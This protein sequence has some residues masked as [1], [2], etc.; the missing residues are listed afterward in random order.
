M[1][2]VFPET[3]WVS[4]AAVQGR[5]SQCPI[6]SAHAAVAT[7]VLPAGSPAAAAVEDPPAAV[8]DGSKRLQVQMPPWGSL[9]MCFD[10]HLAISVVKEIILSHAGFG[11]P[12]EHYLSC[13]GRE[14]HDDDTIESTAIAAEACVVMHRR[15]QGG[16]V[17][18]LFVKTLNGNSS[19]TVHASPYDDVSVLHTEIH[20]KVGIPVAA[21]R[22]IFEGRSLE[23]GRALCDYQVRNM[24]TVHLVLR[25]RG[26][27]P[28][29]L[30]TRS[31]SSAEAGCSSAGLPMSGGSLLPTSFGREDAALLKGVTCVVLSKNPRGTGD[32]PRQFLCHG[33]AQDGQ[34]YAYEATF[35]DAP[36]TCTKVDLKP[37]LRVFG[38]ITALRQRGQ[39]LVCGNPCIPVLHRGMRAC[40]QCFFVGHP[41][42]DGS[43]RVCS[44]DAS[45]SPPDGEEPPSDGEE[46]HHM[47]L[48]H[49]VSP[50]EA[51][52]VMNTHLP[53]TGFDVVSTHDD[54]DR[55][56]HEALVRALHLCVPRDLLEQ[57]VPPRRALQLPADAQALED[58]LRSEYSGPDEVRVRNFASDACVAPATRVACLCVHLYLRVLLHDCVLAQ[59][60]LQSVL[61]RAS[62]L[63][64][65]HIFLLA[66]CD[67][68]GAP[69][70]ESPASTR[71]SLQQCYALLP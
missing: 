5:I 45:R 49:R 47:R 10:V 35:A 27:A 62:I 11:L 50:P 53:S 51:V 37:E 14:L 36:R 2:A 19:V 9:S 71:A 54:G 17:F 43:C 16:G 42:A 34:L 29:Q 70:L 25:L 46:L 30:F 4:A 63:Y 58:Q 6:C 68:G 67:G 64:G 33:R 38:D 24:S 26:G 41:N 18:Q 32:V 1:A 69:F 20:R 28:R 40:N 15:V 55:V 8:P 12:S 22:L 61:P 44:S 52:N 13:E 59:L 57:R 3:R 65:V 31:Y 56:L 21:Q 48:D 7:S 66:T 60:S 39:W 23:S